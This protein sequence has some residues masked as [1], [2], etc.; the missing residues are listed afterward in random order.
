MLV[1]KKTCNEDKLLFKIAHMKQS[2]LRRFLQLLCL[3]ECGNTQNIEH[4]WKL[5]CIVE[6]VI[7][8]Y[9]K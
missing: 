9:T 7:F 2:R 6:Q 8:T 5:I 3:F 4:E 1:C